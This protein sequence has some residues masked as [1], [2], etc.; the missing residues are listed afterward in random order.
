MLESAPFEGSLALSWVRQYRYRHPQKQQRQKQTKTGVIQT[1]TTKETERTCSSRLGN[2]T[3]GLSYSKG[4][5]MGC[6]SQMAVGCLSQRVV[7]CPSQRAVEW[8]V[9]EEWSM[10]DEPLMH[11]WCTTDAPLMHQDWCSSLAIFAR[12]RLLLSHTLSH[13]CIQTYEMGNYWERWRK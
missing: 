11:H 3:S 2:V 9:E 12:K 7:V 6:L 10:T 4:G 8:I 13:N 1:Q 5:R